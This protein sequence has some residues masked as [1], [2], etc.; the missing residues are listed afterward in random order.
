MNQEALVDDLLY[1]ALNDIKPFAPKKEEFKD[2]VIWNTI[3]NDINL[4]SYADCIFLSNNT[5]DFYNEDHSLLHDHLM[6]DIP[7]GANLKMYRNINDLLVSPEFVSDQQTFNSLNHIIQGKVSNK[8]KQIVGKINE[9]YLKNKLNNDFLYGLQSEL[10]IHF[11]HIVNHSSN[12]FN[13][14]FPL[15]DTDLV[16]IDVIKTN[17]NFFM[18]AVVLKV[19]EVLEYDIISGEDDITVL[20]KL[21]TIPKLKILSNFQEGKRFENYE[22]SISL[23][24]VINRDE[25]FEDFDIASCSPTLN[26]W[27][28]AKR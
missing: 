7:T 27:L 10:M 25:I 9:E 28:F 21:N 11:N 26:Q 18:E 16:R 19:T 8:L 23:S 3:V 22:L 1:R 14:Y 2:T 5:S 13:M 4:N 20:C 6:K 17:P 15:I 12:E 24:F